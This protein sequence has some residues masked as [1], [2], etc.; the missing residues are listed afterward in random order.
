MYSSERAKL[1]PVDQVK[2]S[3]HITKCIYTIHYL[4]R[5]KKQS[6]P[7]MWIWSDF[8]LQSYRSLSL[9]HSC[10]HVQKM[11]RKQVK[12]QPRIF[13]DTVNLNGKTV[14]QFM[15]VVNQFFLAKNIKLYKI[16][17]SILDGTN[18]MSGKKNGLQRRIRIFSPF[19]RYIN[20]RIHRQMLYCLISWKML[21]FFC[22]MMLVLGVWKMFPYS[23]EKNLY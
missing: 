17:F 13:F 7:I 12:Q 14:A 18:A 22:I 23:P 16:L 15:D 11:Q 4:N 19:N 9:S 1:T 8:L 10:I 3:M 20:F 2:V 21:S 6:T 5:K